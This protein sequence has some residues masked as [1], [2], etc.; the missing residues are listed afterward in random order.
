MNPSS[1]YRTFNNAA[2]PAEGKGIAGTG[3]DNQG[4]DFRT[5][6]GRIEI[7][8]AKV[9]LPDN[10]TSRWAPTSFAIYYDQNTNINQ[11][12]V[13]ISNIERKAKNAII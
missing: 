3:T 5:I 1:H 10:N 4:A 7:Q 11:A 2:T 8:S 12:S 9:W 13:R 6:R